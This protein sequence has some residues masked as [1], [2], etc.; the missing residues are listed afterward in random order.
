MV[1]F[2]LFACRRADLPTLSPAKLQRYRRVAE[3]A[4]KQ[5]RRSLVPEVVAPADLHE[6]PLDGAA[7][8]AAPKAGASVR[9]VLGRVSS[10]ALTLIT[11][12]EGGLE[13]GEIEALQNRGALAVRLGPRILRAETAP[14][15][16]AAAVL[17]P[18]AL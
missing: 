6:L 10:E 3:E 5:S 1:R 17:L 9:E 15:A 16:L 2:R 7:L 11:G 4:A 18:D 13:T 12:P 14:V 8:L